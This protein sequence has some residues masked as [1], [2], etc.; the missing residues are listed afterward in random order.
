LSVCTK[1]STAF[2]LCFI[3]RIIRK[4]HISRLALAIANSVLSEP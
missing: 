3:P 4:G 1:N 2:F